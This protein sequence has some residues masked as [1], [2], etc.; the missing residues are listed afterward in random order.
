[1]LEIENTPVT[2]GLQTPYMVVKMDN[3]ENWLDTGRISK[4]YFPLLA[5]F[6][7]GN[8]FPQNSFHK[9]LLLTALQVHTILSTAS[10]GSLFKKDSLHC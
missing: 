4:Q 10:F 3:V 9:I 2:G 7:L 1:L 5:N 8:F 6:F